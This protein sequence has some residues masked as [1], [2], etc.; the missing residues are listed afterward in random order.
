[1]LPLIKLPAI[2]LEWCTSNIYRCL[3]RRGSCSCLRHILLPWGF[4]QL[5]SVFF[6]F[7]VF[8]DIVYVL[9]KPALSCFNIRFVLFAK[10]RFRIRKRCTLW[11][12]LMCLGGA[13]FGSFFYLEEM[14]NLGEVLFSLTLVWSRP[15]RVLGDLFYWG[16]EG[17]C[18]H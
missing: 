15:L 2:L 11:L 5:L 9:P 12:L 4:M 17:L 13:K 1:M 16:G 14:N 7:C 8:P 3:K 6:L 10:L 18:L